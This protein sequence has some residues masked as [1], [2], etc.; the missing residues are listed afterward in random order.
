VNDGPRQ[1]TATAGG[2]ASA[3]RLL[4]SEVS[5]TFGR[6]TV[7]KAM[8]LQL[9]PG[10]LH[11]LVGQNG[12]GKSTLV[13]ILTGVHAPDPG[14]TIEVDGISLGPV[15]RV[16]AM[17]QAG[18]SVVHQTL[19]LID[20][21]SVLENVRAGRLRGARFSRRID[22]RSE[23]E[24]V[25]E[26]L[27]RL[28]CRLDPDATV[29]RLSAEDRATV[30]IARAFQDHQP[31][32]GVII[33]DESTRA[34][35]TDAFARFYEMVAAVR[36]AGAAVL[37]ISHRIEEVLQVADR[38]TVLRDGSVTGEGVPASGLDETALVKLML[39]HELRRTAGRPRP[40]AGS[41]ERPIVARARDVVG[42]GARGIS[43]DVA[44][45]E[46]VGLTGLIGAGF[47]ELPYLLAGAA[48]AQAGTLAID[49]RELSLA[50]LD[51]GVRQLA[52]AGVA[53]VPERR[54]E[55]GL[56]FELTMLENMTLP[57]VRA[58]GSRFWTGGAWQR[59]EAADM[60]ARLDIRPSRPEAV[61][62]TLSGGNQQ[63]VLLAKWLASQPRL[64]LLHEPTQA[65]DVGAREDIIAV[66]RRAAAG[67]CAVIVAGSDPQELSALCDRVLVLRDGCVR[68][69]LTGDFDE[70]AI[71][72]AT[73]GDLPSA[74]Q[75]KP[76]STA[77]PSILTG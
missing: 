30:A 68:T 21:A 29:G 53:L 7:L 58:R 27:E 1:T 36:R 28:G 14:G 61:V 54:A 6:Q 8:K 48:A 10:E 76:T 51:G 4:V 31:G 59:A 26:V 77:P 18:L 57:R 15:V 2:E 65:V 24:Q 17:R 13:K 73:F 45:G 20:D 35:T 32:R 40:A 72:R 56:A 63:K 62:G 23:R 38:I 75:G 25:V 66:V 16:S 42:G 46:I 22:W 52:A 12:S 67:G 33:F 47:E 11:G 70:D 19:G 49:D 74:D 60:I 37:L 50:G 3:P 64:L 5:K 55:E 71:V 34:L 44:A 39:G 69:E 43:F 9:A 41:G